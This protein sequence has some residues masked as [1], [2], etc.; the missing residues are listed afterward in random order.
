[1]RGGSGLVFFI[2][3]GYYKIANERYLQKNFFELVFIL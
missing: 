3:E 2:F 1:M